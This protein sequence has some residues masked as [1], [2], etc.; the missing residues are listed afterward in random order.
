MSDS[1]KYY[2]V[3]LLRRVV[4]IVPCM[5]FQFFFKYFLTFLAYS[6]NDVYTTNSSTTYSNIPSDCS[7]FGSKFETVNLKH[8]VILNVA[9]NGTYWIGAKIGYER[10]INPLGMFVYHSV[11]HILLLFFITHVRIIS[12]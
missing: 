9:K 6:E 11:L 1:Q 3:I 10:N 12:Y 5:R 8:K 4:Y 7:L 2:V